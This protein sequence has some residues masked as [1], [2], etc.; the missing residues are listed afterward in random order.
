MSNRYFRNFRNAEAS[1]QNTRRAAVFAASA[2][3]ADHPVTLSV[4]HYPE[5]VQSACRRG[6]SESTPS[7]RHSNTGGID[8]FIRR[9]A[10]SPEGAFVDWL[11]FT[12]KTSSFLNKTNCF[13]DYDIVLHFSTHLERIL[14]FGVTEERK[15]GRF[16]YRQSFTLGNNWGL[17]CIGG[18]NDTVMVSLTGEGGMAAKK[19]WQHRLYK[20]LKTL[21]QPR[22]TRVDLA[23]DFFEGEYTVDQ[24]LADYH[25]GQ[26]SLGARLPDVEQKGNWIKPNG[27]GRSLYVGNRASGKMVRVYEKG[28]Q[29]G[30]GFSE[31]RPKWNR[32]EGE[33]HNQD[34]EIPLD[35]L[36]Y[37]GQYLAGMYPA[38]AFISTRQ[39]RIKTRKATA[40]VTYDAAI[41]T[42]RHQF[43]EY[44]YFMRQIEGSAEAVLD[45]LVRKGIPKR[46]DFSDHRHAWPSLKPRYVSFD[47][48][49]ALTFL[50]A[51]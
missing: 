18:Q 32:V 44:L 17:V 3:G 46:L 20:L 2:A 49:T 27:K 14:G 7:P 51:A 34:R 42:V 41:H 21:D 11:H 39:T 6:P 23:R 29:L 10:A 12:C 24:A 47:Q 28:L 33:L 40:K 4:S 48:A 50:G 16:F 30:R 1:R 45:R 38:L 22:I 26:F 19:G 37:P 13:D 15:T 31:L 25:A 36:V 8:A 35:V 43:G 5:A 9:Q